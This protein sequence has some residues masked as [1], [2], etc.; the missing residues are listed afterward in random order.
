MATHMI[1]SQ[2]RYLG[3]Q[4]NASRYQ[5]GRIGNQ[6]NAPWAWYAPSGLAKARAAVKHGR[7]IQI[8]KTH[9]RTL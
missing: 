9:R 8:A 7:R 3:T 6:Q 4:D 1:Y 2:I 5:K